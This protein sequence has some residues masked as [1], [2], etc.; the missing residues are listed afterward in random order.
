MY[1]WAKDTHHTH[2][3]RQLQKGKFSVSYWCLSFRTTFPLFYQPL[4]F[5]RKILNPLFLE[6]FQNLNP[7][8]FIKGRTR[9]GSGHRKGG[10]HLW[11]PSPYVQIFAKIVNDKLV[12]FIKKLHHRCLTEF[13]IHLTSMLVKTKTLPTQ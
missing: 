11:A 12:F 1:K 7:R 10:V 5:Y 3:K 9:E 13:L 6:K 8:P 2:C 4:T